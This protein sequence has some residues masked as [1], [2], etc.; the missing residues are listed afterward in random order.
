M[1]LETA[2]FTVDRL[3]VRIWYEG[4]NRLGPAGRQ[5]SNNREQI[6]LYDCAVDPLRNGRAALRTER[7]RDTD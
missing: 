5:K 2:D 6:R 4:D 7:V 1:T 3:I